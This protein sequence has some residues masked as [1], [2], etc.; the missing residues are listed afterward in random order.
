[1][2]VKTEYKCTNCGKTSIKWAGRCTVCGEYNTLEEVIPLTTSN[3]INKNRL[4][5]S[6]YSNLSN[7]VSLL[8][9]VDHKHLE[10][11]K[12]NIESLD[13]LLSTNQGLV[14][15]SVTLLAG[16]PGIGKS[17]LLLQL[18][19]IFSTLSDKKVLYIS[20]EESDSQIALRGKRM[21]LPINNIYVANMTELETILD[22]IEMEKPNFMIID[23][24]QTIY[25]MQLS[26]TPGSVSQIKEC[27]SAIAR[28]AK[29]NNIDTFMIGHVTKDG[30]IAGPQ[31]LEHIVDTVL[32]FE[33]SAESTFRTLKSSK[34]RFGANNEVAIFEMTEKG[35][36]EVKDPSSIFMEQ[37]YDEGSVGTAILST[38]YKNQAMMIEIQSL[39]DTNN[40]QYSKRIANGI[41]YNRLSIIIAI[42]NK[43][44]D[45]KLH[46]FDIFINVVAGFKLDDTASD[47][48]VFLSILSSFQNKAMKSQTA[49]FGEIS[50]NG[51]LRLTKNFEKRISV[52]EKT[53]FKNIIMPF[54]KD[55][56]TL[57][58]IKKNNPKIKLIMCKNVTEAYMAYQ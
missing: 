21:E 13:T 36:I 19:S 46:Q 14:K 15:G 18:S 29:Q 40:S 25:S 7:K 10:T 32:Y 8:S 11:T 24:I 20:G 39:I 34:N 5:N 12:T 45:L 53:G 56:K 41:E 1:M 16:D 22:V 58:R 2:A 9:E 31:V 51:N 52:A 3:I 4:S 38:L 23:S 47:L 30:D 55:K 50:L 54:I 48:A 42:I 43:L 6:G 44:T 35:L 49:I 33:G 17:T 57:D 27:T 37:D 28:K 26:S